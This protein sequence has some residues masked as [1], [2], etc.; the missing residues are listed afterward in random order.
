MTLQALKDKWK[1][2]INNWDVKNLK[3]CDEFV[4]DCINY[5]YFRDYVLDERPDMANKK[6]QG[7]KFKRP[8][9]IVADSPLR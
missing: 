8:A 9:G 5:E 2:E 4:A 1:D 6:R 3:D 7:L